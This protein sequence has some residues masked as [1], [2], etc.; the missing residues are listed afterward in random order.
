MN[1]LL[2]NEGKKF[3]EEYLHNKEIDYEVFHPWRKTWQFVMLHSYRV[4]GYVEKI[5]MDNTYN[6]TDDE[7]TITYLAAILHDIGRIHQ[8][9]K[10]ALL[11]R[12]IVDDWLCK[13]DNIAQMVKDKKRLLYLIEQHSNKGIQ[14]DDMCLNILKDADI[15]DEIGIMSI[16]MTSYRLDV[17]D[18][19]YFNN[20]YESINKKEIPY[21]LE[22]EKILI[23]D[24]AKKILNQKKHFIQMFLNQLKI[25]LN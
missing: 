13:N 18:P 7:I 12:F 19:Y 14:H 20:L 2:I 5:L 11:S 25:E 10:H 1:Q 3:L 4:C 15:L 23:T 21:C 16:F 17:N 22:Q 24:S 9:E 6:L 8:R